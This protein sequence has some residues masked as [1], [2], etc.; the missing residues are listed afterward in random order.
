MVPK[1]IAPI[2]PYMPATELKMTAT[3][4]ARPGYQAAVS[5]TDCSREKSGFGN[6]AEKH[7]EP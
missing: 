7:P 6:R 5:S 1:G 3:M 4:P 2:E